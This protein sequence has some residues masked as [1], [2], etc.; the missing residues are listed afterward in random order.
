MLFDLLFRVYAEYLQDQ[1]HA[2]LTMGSLPTPRPTAR[3][4]QLSC[5]PA[6]SFC[7]KPDVLGKDWEILLW[8]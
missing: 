7:W 1:L 6:T 2:S 5:D 3:A 4:S 8:S